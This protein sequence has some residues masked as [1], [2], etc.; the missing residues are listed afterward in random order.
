MTIRITSPALS[1]TQIQDEASEFTFAELSRLNEEFFGDDLETNVIDDL[2]ELAKV[3]KCSNDAV[4]LT[5][6]KTNNGVFFSCPSVQLNAEGKLILA[7][8]AKTTFE[9]VH[10]AK[11]KMYSIEGT[12]LTFKTVIYTND[13]K[14]VKGVNLMLK[15]DADVDGLDIEVEYALQVKVTT[16]QDFKV[17]AKALQSGESLTS[18]QL[19]QI[20]SGGS[21]D[22]SIKPWMLSKGFYMITR[23]KPAVVLPAL[24]IHEGYCKRINDTGEFIDDEEYLVSMNAAPFIQNKSNILVNQARLGTPIVFGIDGGFRMSMGISTIG[25]ARILRNKDN[26]FNSEGFKAFKAACKSAFINKRRQNASSVLSEA[27]LKEEG[28]L[29]LDKRNKKPVDAANTIVPTTETALVTP[30][31]QDAPF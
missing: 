4:I 14:E 24:T 11:T 10:D 28:Q 23:M 2:L 9:L 27:Q 6:Y 15:Y 19:V 7:L 16:E 29:Y 12:D 13:N 22:I 20:G 30:S 3:L 21:F 5:T 25:D 8:G 17:I 18:D 1:A 31:L 26:A